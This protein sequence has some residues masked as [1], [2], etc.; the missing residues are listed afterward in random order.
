MKELEGACPKG[1]RF[2]VQLVDAADRGEAE[3]TLAA[4]F[5]ASTSDL[6]LMPGTFR[7]PR[8]DKRICKPW[9]FDTCGF[10]V[11]APLAWRAGE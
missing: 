11:Y 9:K 1:Y 4:M 7:A 3:R 2:L 5:R 6:I 10:R 8:D